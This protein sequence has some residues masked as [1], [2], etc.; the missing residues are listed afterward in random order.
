MDGIYYDASQDATLGGNNHS[1]TTAVS[2]A[3][4]KAYIDSKF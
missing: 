1:T 4:A 3:A 2:E